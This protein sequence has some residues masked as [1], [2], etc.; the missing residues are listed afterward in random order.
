[1]FD[2]G[3]INLD[4]ETNEEMDIANV[5]YY[6]DSDDWFDEFNDT[7]LIPRKKVRRLQHI[8]EL[9]ATLTTTKIS[10]TDT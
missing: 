9:P 3:M 1:M 8:I 5:A 4:D 10:A 2:N 7:Y 6:D